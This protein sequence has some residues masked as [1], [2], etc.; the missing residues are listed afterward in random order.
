MK[1][2]RPTLEYQI[3]QLLNVVCLLR[4]AASVNCLN[5]DNLVITAKF[6]Y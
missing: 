6:S 2:S 3:R 5:K 4:N 1:H